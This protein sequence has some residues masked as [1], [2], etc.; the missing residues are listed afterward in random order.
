MGVLAAELG[1][2]SAPS[3]Y[4]KNWSIRGKSNLYMRTVRLHPKWCELVERSVLTLELAGNLNRIL[5]VGAAGSPLHLRLQRNPY[6]IAKDSNLC[7][8]EITA[9]EIGGTH[10]MSANG[11]SG[12]TIIIKGGA[13]AKS[14]I[15]RKRHHCAGFVLME[16]WTLAG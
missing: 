5:P 15:G 7:A 2:A 16:G 3:A 11:K 8:V 13:M 1:W 12:L 4:A 9:E 10:L 14:G 6:V